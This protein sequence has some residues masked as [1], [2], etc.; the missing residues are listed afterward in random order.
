V[1]QGRKTDGPK[2]ELVEVPVPEESPLVT[3]CANADPPNSKLRPI[4]KYFMGCP[5]VRGRHNPVFERRSQFFWHVSRPVVCST[6]SANP[7]ASAR[8]ELLPQH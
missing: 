7:Q 6:C 4:V 3:L 8:N 5:L 1:G 2:A